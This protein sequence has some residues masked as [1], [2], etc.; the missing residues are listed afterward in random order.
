MACEK[1]LLRV[2]LITI[3]CVQAYPVTRI[4]SCLR[5]PV[6]LKMI[7]DKQD[8][9]DRRHAPPTSVVCYRL[10]DFV[11]SRFFLGAYAPFAPIIAEQLDRMLRAIRTVST[12]QG[13]SRTIFVASPA[14][15]LGVLRMRR[16]FFCHRGVIDL[17]SC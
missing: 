7:E 11:V 5:L 4:L 17:E 9:Q 13:I 2:R 15:A 12:D 1:K 3:D 6:H 8:R 16:E 10:L 14:D